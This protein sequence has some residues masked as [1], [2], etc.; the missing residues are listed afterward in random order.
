MGDLLAELEADDELRTRLEI[1]LFA[2]L[3]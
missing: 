1:A 3:D 2:A